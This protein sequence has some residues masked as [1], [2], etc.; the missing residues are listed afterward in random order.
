M[1]I[2]ARTVSGSITAMQWIIIYFRYAG[3]IPTD[4]WGMAMFHAVLCTGLFVLVWQMTK[5]QS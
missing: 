4:N 2:L 3:Y 5:D 1:K